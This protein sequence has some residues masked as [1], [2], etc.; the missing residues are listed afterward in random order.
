M[1]VQAVKSVLVV[2]GTSAERVSRELEGRGFFAM[3]YRLGLPAI[4][5]IN[6]GLRYHVAVVGLS[7]PDT[8]GYTVMETSKRVNPDTPVINLTSYC[9]K[10]DGRLLYC[11]DQVRKGD[12]KELVKAIEQHCE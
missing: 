7:F 3:P 5:D 11:D 6:H 8:D 9:F 10:P 2:D 4:D 1:P 12:I